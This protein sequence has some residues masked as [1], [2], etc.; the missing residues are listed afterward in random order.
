MYNQ[1]FIKLRVYKHLYTSHKNV[2]LVP[3]LVK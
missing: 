3:K 1:Q 2:A